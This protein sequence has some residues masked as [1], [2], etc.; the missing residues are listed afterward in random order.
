MLRLMMMGTL[1]VTIAAASGCGGSLTPNGGTGGS[2]GT[3]GGANNGGRPT[4]GS[5]GFGGGVGGADG[6]LCTLGMDSPQ[7]WARGTDYLGLSFDYDGPA[8]VAQS[9]TDSL[10]LSISVP[11]DAGTAD[12]GNGTTGV[13]ITGMTPM[14]LFPVG[15]R[16]WLTKSKD[17]TQGFG[18]PPS[19]SF[20]VRTGQGGTLL[21][22]GAIGPYGPLSFPVQVDQ[23]TVV[24]SERDGECAPNS[25]ISFAGAVVT[26][27]SPVYV[28]PDE[29]GSILL[30]GALYQVRLFAASEPVTQP[31]NCTDFFGES[32]VQIDVR[33]TNLANLIGG[34]PIPG[35]DTR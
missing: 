13:Q 9:S 20:A 31:V 28:A 32:D 6:S 24:C 29:L 25:S 16:V 4:G 15:A 34:L 7:L 27:D 26:G 12:A 30:G 23:F 19:S 21:F 33:S 2:P 17:G 18:P 8:S 10:T 35:L 11:A 3:G 5:T 1:V 14:P 22:G